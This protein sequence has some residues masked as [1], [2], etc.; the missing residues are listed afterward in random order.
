MKPKTKSSVIIVCITVLVISLANWVGS[1]VYKRFDLTQDHRYTLSEASLQMLK[2][3]DS[4]L[5]IDVFLEGEF[6]SEFRRLKRET[7]QLLEEFA[8]HSKQVKFSF[9]NPLEDE[10]NRDQIIQQLVQRGLQPLQ[11]NVNEGTKSSQE[12]IFPWALA[13]FNNQTVKISLI[14][15]SIGA[16]Q[17]D[18]ITNSIQHLEYTFAEG[19]NKLVKPKSKTIAILKGNGQLGDLYIADFLKT[20]KS[21]YKIAAF[22]LDSVS[23]QPQK[24]LNQLKAYDLIISAKATK[25]F[26]EAEK[27]VLDQY[28]MYGGK[29]LWLTESVSMDQD[30]LLNESGRAIALP[31]ALNLDDFFFKYGIRINPVLVSDMYS[32]PITLA[33]GE[34][35]NAQFQPLKWPYSPL[36]TSNPN[37]SIT[38][39]LNLIKFD[40]A[41]TIDTLKN[42]ISKTILL[43]SSKLSK[44]EGVP[45]EIRLELV[46]QEPNPDQFTAG[47][48]H[49]AVLLEGAF[50]SV[51]NNR[52]KPFKITNEKNKSVPTKMI[53]VAD[54][55]IIK[56]DVIRNQPQE[57]G[58]DR[59]TG[60]RFGNKEF[61]ENAVQYLLDDNGLIDIR[62]KA[63]VIPFLDQQKVQNEKSK[64]LFINIA[65]PLLFLTIFSI[66]FTYLR[67]R[68]Y[69]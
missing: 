22:T 64:W 33:I 4:P 3:V 10:A 67:K 8:M 39:N 41:N 30:S 50:T 55:N 17:Q 58:F 42:S 27:F 35:S 68:K 9:F 53:V 59:W 2:H 52:V 44:L 19:F 25:P 48:Q 49:L 36:A 37:H 23:I 28:T 46:T 14:K 45:K 24:T 32:A 18:L 26:T 69:Q 54:G 7:H 38:S 1:S 5:I 61:L 29:S 21:Q 65:L 57:L 6:S 47:P 63:V 15:N 11:L 40:F 16:S 20:I 34:G 12:L 13:S 31:N 51:Y 56:N 43:Q 66:V 60:Q 62:S